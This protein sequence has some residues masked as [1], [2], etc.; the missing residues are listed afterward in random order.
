MDAIVSPPA[1]LATLEDQLVQWRNR[2]VQADYTDSFV[3][4]QAEKAECDRHIA[5]LEGQIASI[6]ETL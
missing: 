5:E 2:R 4:M 3:K 6:R 1:L